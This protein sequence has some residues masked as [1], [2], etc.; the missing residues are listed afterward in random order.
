MLTL[1]PRL[2]GLALGIGLVVLGLLCG[3]LAERWLVHRRPRPGPAAMG[4]H[5]AGEHLLGR[6]TRDLDLS[7]EQEA[8][9]A[10][11]LEASRDS[12]AQVQSGLRERMRAITTRTRAEIRALLTPDQQE[13]YRKALRRMSRHQRRGRRWGRAR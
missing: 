8:D 2:K 9:I 4:P 6:L 11:I 13:E 5:R 7:P 12:I 3:I 1:T 10:R